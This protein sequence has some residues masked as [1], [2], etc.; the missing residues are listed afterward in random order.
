MNDQEFWKSNKEVQVITNPNYDSA[1]EFSVDIIEDLSSG[2]FSSV[3]IDTPVTDLVSTSAS[4]LYL[5]T[6]WVMVL[7]LLLIVRNVFK[8]CRKG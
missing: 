1:L 2:G 6:M 4:I 3:S 7:I 8:R 5:W